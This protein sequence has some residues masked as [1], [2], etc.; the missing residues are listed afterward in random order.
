MARESESPFFDWPLS[1]VYYFPMPI[2]TTEQE[3]LI[4]AACT[5]QKRAYAPYSNFPVGAA[6]LTNN[7][8]IVTGVN[9]ENAS[10]GLTNCAERNG[11]GTMI[12]LGDTA[13][14]AVAV[15]SRNGVTPCG[16]CRQ[17]L[18]EFAPYDIPVWMIA[19]DTGM[20][21]KMTLYQLIPDGFNKALLDEATSG[22]TL[23]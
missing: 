8:R 9:V 3:K 15:S 18:L 5:I 11:I 14:T 22:N 4:E 10:Y 12:G 17:V 6:L 20:V 21:R 1:I 7:G 23:L 13:I 19:T 16:A 2:S